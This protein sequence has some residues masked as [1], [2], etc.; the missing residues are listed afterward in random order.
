M[1]LSFYPRKS[2]RPLTYFKVAK[3]NY[4]GKK[5]YLWRNLVIGLKVHRRQFFEQM[6]ELYVILRAKLRLPFSPLARKYIDADF[7]LSPQKVISQKGRLYFITASPSSFFKHNQLYAT[8]SA[9]CAISGPL[10]DH[11]PSPLIRGSF[12]RSKRSGQASL[13]TRRPAGGLPHPTNLN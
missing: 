5:P 2:E 1:L 10:P 13:P 6:G 3:T 11:L 9:I 7:Q 8:T 12:L 4:Q